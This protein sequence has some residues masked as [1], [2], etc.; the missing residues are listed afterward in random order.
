MGDVVERLKTNAALLKALEK[1]SH[2]KPSSG[3][4]LE[5]R[6]SFIYGSIGGEGAVT[7]E[8]IKQILREQGAVQ[9]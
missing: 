4:L 7:R 9:P 3:E 6:V 8:K 5:Q 1:A 2:V